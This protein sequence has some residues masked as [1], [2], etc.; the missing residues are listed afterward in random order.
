MY[1]RS[2]LYRSSVSLMAGCAAWLG[3]MAVASATSL[4]PPPPVGDAGSGLATAAGDLVFPEP[5][6]TGVVLNPSLLLRIDRAILDPLRL[7]GVPL[8]PPAIGEGLLLRDASGSLLAPGALVTLESPRSYGEARPPLDSHVEI[9]TAPLVLAEQTH[10]E[11]LSRIAV[12]AGPEERW[13]ACLQDEYRLIGEFDTGTESDRAAPVI[14]SIELRPSP[15]ECLMALNIAASDDHTPPQ[16]LRFAVWEQAFQGTNLVLPTN[17]QARGD[18]LVSLQVVPVDASGN[19]GQAFAVEVPTC[20]QSSQAEGS[21]VDLLP[22]ETSTPPRRVL[23]EPEQSSCAMTQARGAALDGLWG[24]GCA[25]LFMAGRRL[26]R[27]T[28]RTC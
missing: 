2:E 17:A 15:G 16:A 4:A 28:R 9:A 6:A 24:W 23:R 3:G 11:V 27:A 14:T 21:F 12:C 22:A 25:A 19:R 13:V 20:A 1:Q 8:E 5:G 26:L 10:Y 7:G 18:E